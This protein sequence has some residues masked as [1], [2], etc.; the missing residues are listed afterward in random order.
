MS[1]TLKKLSFLIFFCA[2]MITAGC[3]EDSATGLSASDVSGGVGA[4]GAGVTVNPEPLSA[5]LFTVG[6]AA[7]GLHKAFKKHK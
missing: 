3:K 5:A 1:N 4:P 7:W 6:M 2:L